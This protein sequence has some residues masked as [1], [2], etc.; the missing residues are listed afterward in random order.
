MKRKG[1]ELGRGTE[2]YDSYLT[3]PLQ[4][5]EKL[6]SPDCLGEKSLVLGRGLTLNPLPVQPLVGSCLKN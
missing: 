4:L 6:Q 1:E 3:D 5:M 2:D